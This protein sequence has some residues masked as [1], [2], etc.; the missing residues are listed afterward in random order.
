[1]NKIFKVVW[2]KVRN[3]YV[4]VSEI[5]KNTVSGVGKRNRVK[6]FSL[7]ATLAAVALTSSFF[8]PN[9]GCAYEIQIADYSQ[10]VAIVDYGMTEWKE[11][12]LKANQS[13]ELRNGVYYFDEDTRTN[14]NEII[15]YVSQ[16]IGTT[17][18]YVRNG[19]II[20]GSDGKVTQISGR[21]VEGSTLTTLQHKKVSL[22]NQNGVIVSTVLG[23]NLND[24]HLVTYGAATNS[25]GVSAN[26]GWAYKFDWDG[27]GNFDDRI[28]LDEYVNGKQTVGQNTEMVRVHLGS[29]GNYYY[30]N[31]NQ[32]ETVSI[33][34]VYFLVDS[35]GT[36]AYA[37][38]HRTNGTF[39]SR[40]VM[41]DNGEFL[42][43]GVDNTGSAYT[44]WGAEADDRQTLLKD[45]GM[46][47]HQ[48]H[49]TLDHLQENDMMLSNASTKGLL[50]TE[51][52][53]DGTGGTIKL[54]TNNDTALDDGVVIS[55]TA[56]DGE[57][58]KISFSDT[59]GSEA[60]ELETG[61]RVS[62]VQSGNQTNITVNGNTTTITDTNTNTHIKPGTYSVTD[63]A[64]VLD[65][66]ENGSDISNKVTINDVASTAD[67]SNLSNRITTNTANIS[68][69]SSNITQILTD[70]KFDLGTEK[71]SEITGQITL[72]NSELDDIGAVNVT[73]LPASGGIGGADTKLTFGSGSD[74]FSFTTG[75]IVSGTVTN[76][77]LSQLSINGVPYNLYN[78]S[79]LVHHF[80]IDAGNIGPDGNFHGWYVT[81]KDKKD[82]S[83]N[84]IKFGDT[85][86]ID[87]DTEGYSV[88]SNNINTGTNIYTIKDTAGNMVVLDDVASAQ[89][90]N[91]RFTTV[92]TNI[93]N[94]L[95]GTSLKFGVVDKNAKTIGLKDVNGN[96]IVGSN[97][98]V[99][100]T[101]SATN[102]VQI[103][104][105]GTDGFSVS[106]GSKVVGIVNANE[107]DNSSGVLKGL[108]INGTD[109]AIYDTKLS[110][111]TPT[112]EAGVGTTYKITDTSGA[113]VELTG[114]A[115]YADG[116]KKVIV[117]NNSI[118]VVRNSGGSAGSI[119]IEQ[120]GG[121]RTGEAGNYLY[122][123][124][125]IIV[126]DGTNSIS[127]TTGSIVSATGST[128]NGNILDTITI[129]GKEFV[130]PSHANNTGDFNDY[131]LHV[132]SA[133][134]N[135]TNPKMGYVVGDDGLV[136]LQVYDAAKGNGFQDV[137]IKDVARATDLNLLETKVGSEVINK[138]NTTIVSSAS[139]VVSHINNLYS[140][141]NTDTDWRLVGAERGGSDGN[142]S[143]SGAY[144]VDDYN[145]ITL[146]VQN[147]K[148]MGVAQSIVIENVAKETELATLETLVGKGTAF[149][150]TGNTIVT[151]PAS[152]VNH[153][154]NL[155][156][157]VNTAIQDASKHSSV[158][159]GND[160]LVLDIDTT[161]S[162][163][164]ITLNDNV[165]LGTDDMKKIFINGTSGSMFVGKVRV[166]NYFDATGAR[167]GADITGLTNV[168]WNP[169]EVVDSVGRAA[170]E[171][172]LRQA[173]STVSA[174]G[175]KSGQ[176]TAYNY[177]DSNDAQVT[178]KASIKL[179]DNGGNL[180]TTIDGLK[181]TTLV[182]D[183]NNVGSTDTNN[184]YGKTYTISD[185]NGN[186]VVLKDVASATELQKVEGRTTNVENRVTVVE[187][188]T[189]NVENRVTDVENRTTNVENR[190]T[191]VENRTTNVENRVAVVENR[192]TNVENR[193][194]VVENRT[195]N[196]EN[197]V[198]DVENRTTNVENRV[199][200]V[201]NRTTNVENRV[202]VVENNFITQ[203]EIVESTGSIELKNN[204]GDIKATVNGL[205]DYA[206]EARTD[207]KVEG[208]KITLDIVDRFNG[209]AKTA[210][211]NDVAKASDLGN[212]DS[213]RDDLKD[214]NSTNSV[215]NAVNKLDDK[216]NQGWNYTVN[217]VKVPEQNIKMG[218]T[219]NFKDDA[220][221]IEL[222]AESGGVKV[223][224]KDDVIFNKVTVGGVVVD[225]DGINAGNKKITNVDKGDVSANSQDAVNGSQL[226]ATNQAVINNYA[227]IQQLQGND[228]YLDSRINQ[229][230]SKVNKVGAG[231]AALAA[232]HPMDFDPDDKLSF[233][234]GAG[235]YA[236]ETATA[237][238]AFYRPNEKVMMNVA[239]T[240]G[241]GENMVN[242]GVSFALDRTNHVSNSRTAMAKE[243]VDL[244]EQVATQGQQIAQLVALVQQL[245]GVQQPVVPAEQLF[246]D[247]PE[248]HW[249]YEYVN[250]LV[251]KGILEGYPDGTFGG[252]RTMTR[253]EFAAM[254]FRAMEQ[255][256][257]LSEQIRQEFEKELGRVRV[258]RVKGADNDPNKIE[259]VR[260]N[261][262]ADRDNYGS[263]IVQVKH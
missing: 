160:N 96:V 37:F 27:D 169:G 78:A 126:G 57:N 39:Y 61:S 11:K 31:G 245:A 76:G 197:R 202:T 230:G 246:P 86:L 41:G 229:L 154:N 102:D 167:V 236:G 157:K 251:S 138:D 131:T 2:S 58:T 191:D 54:K 6:R 218:G 4:V 47:V 165:V 56:N 228:Q 124:R 195:T 73:V 135:T 113:F 235:N 142:Y 74:A 68:S 70:D 221:N 15:T 189:T 9:W 18:Y 158:S 206:L 55:R 51:N 234:V 232:L 243:I 146:N 5:A 183:D 153:I 44:Y 105:G 220:K 130:L 123:D 168:T 187:N 211:I 190:V 20:S 252:D 17:Q 172:Q 95:N 156:G 10:Y 203:G 254:L 63:N 65:M 35:N 259:R 23:D 193:V 175:I 88:K 110:S 67:I 207:Y 83:G 192:T 66:R 263:K 22:R 198:T 151:E 152:V 159:V 233:A 108:S 184:P 32:R 166:N 147:Q 111:V 164:K 103:T 90:V 231:A 173:I 240:Y 109:Y 19:Y 247:V 29:D 145:K 262:A 77:V 116:I 257:V 205:S 53:T 21:P 161:V 112:D 139:S 24:V 87:D 255:G 28:K 48:L 38:R 204:S 148:T 125:T 42:L 81:N 93:A 107:I 217:G 237:L 238:G 69:N 122:P 30:Q 101:N 97:I 118:N 239:G 89:A 209:T 241:N 208:G 98:T 117:D 72:K 79:S 49:E 178:G 99:E 188:R 85:M 250:T 33:N 212:V 25:A 141:V 200:D 40:K 34:D 50:V 224:I 210:V 196:V 174:A 176:V 119:V 162:D 60:I 114:I 36:A 248:N 199:T 127:L 186:E 150:T 214:A 260:V 181:D 256:V 45:S 16:Y 136:K 242:M 180:V 253:Y 128:V 46:T 120:R 170:T 75:S 100:S 91:D 179:F 226:H 201:E 52:Q 132:G 121:E 92:N 115:K 185:T 7:G 149:D 182:A 82:A 14:D 129:N 249:A 155:Y 1:M 177:R 222:T 244:R 134:D 8:L 144:T 13:L 194:T 104:F 106:A 137:Y 215:V 213:L 94:I 84:L 64:I 163:Y 219:I 261:K 227:N 62:V 216:V 12:A 140:Y 225:S 171:A 143:Y 80:A 223:S 59:Y 133:L 43:T 3:A 26:K 71:I 258:D